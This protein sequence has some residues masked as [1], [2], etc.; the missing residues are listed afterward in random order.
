[1]PELPLK[2]ILIVDDQSENQHL[3]SQGLIAQG[4]WVHCVGSGLTALEQVSVL[5]PN[6]ILLDTTLPDLDGYDVCK[7]LK[8]LSDVADIPVIFLSALDDVLDKVRAFEVGGADY[9]TKPFHL[10]ELIVRINHQLR[11]QAAKLEI[12]SLNTDLELR[13]QTR[14][15]ELQGV[16]QD[17]RREISERRRAEERL[18]HDALHDALTGLPNRNLFIERIE[19]CLRYARR[20]KDYRFAVLFI[21]LDRFK[22][23]NDSLGHLV[24][25]QLL[26][27][28]AQRLAQCMRAIDTV[29]RLGGDEFT[30]LLEQVK[31][32][33]DAIRVAERIQEALKLPFTLEGHM[34]FSSASVGIAIGSAEYTNREDLLRDADIAM[35]KA[36][37]MGRSRY[38]IFDQKMYLRTLQLLQLESDLRQ[39]LERQEF[40]VYYQP[41]VSLMTGDLAGFEALVR[42]QHPRRGFISPVEFI[43]LAEDT[44]LIV[45]LGEWVLREACR[46]MREWQVEFLGAS[47]LRMS[48]NL[49]GQQLQ[50]PGLIQ[51][52]DQVLAETGL[53]GASLRLEITESMLMERTVSIIEI[54]HEIRARQI[55]LSID[56]FG[57]GYSSLSYLHRFPVNS[58]KIDR[59]F[60]SNMNTDPENFEIVRTVITLAHT[61]SMDVIAEGVEIPEQSIQLRALG[62]EYSQGYLF[63]KPLDAQ[64]ARQLI[65]Q[66]PCWL[67]ELEAS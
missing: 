28:I 1:M 64:A 66:P 40:V 21:D 16:N 22:I 8:S 4:Y 43:P 41:V 54:M 14:T 60:V 47:S 65:A 31:E 3:L 26:I 24:G 62:C 52:I 39:A 29:A 20:Y 35:Y 23:V 61:L 17:L 25:D 32:D 27:A 58:L 67:M 6:L 56:D 51:K 37:E 49:A 48:V 45:P 18:I 12:Q 5:Q 30:I 36:K 33:I 7:R 42:W 63:S 15:A 34:I 59:S 44:G 11:L 13:V 46:Q 9:V 55:Q 19:N 38:A 57:T 50:E 53:E 2:T 10:E